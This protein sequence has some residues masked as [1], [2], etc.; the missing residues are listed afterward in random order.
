MC[1]SQVTITAS[2]R[3]ET[4]E[5]WFVFETSHLTFAAQMDALTTDG[6]LTGVR[7]DTRKL[8]PEDGLGEGRQITSS[9]EFYVGKS[10]IV[11]VAEIRKPLFS[12]TGERLL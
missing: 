8:M 5:F 7:H 9:S 3:G 10:A 1:Y 4:R 11:T 12:A 2:N 6:G